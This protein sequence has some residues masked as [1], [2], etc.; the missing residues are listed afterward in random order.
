MSKSLKNDIISHLIKKGNYDPDVDN[1]IIDM[2]LDNLEYAQQM[3]SRLDVEG[4]VVDMA[5]GNGI[6]STKMNPA[7]GIYQM[8]QRNIHQAAAKLGISRKDRMM[9]KIV[10]QK[11]ADDFDNIMG[12]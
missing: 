7:F 11:E 3:K 12:S 8:C 2:I 10:E 9:L 6:V 4:C 5:N 1:Y